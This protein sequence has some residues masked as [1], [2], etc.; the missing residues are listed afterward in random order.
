MQAI[1]PQLCVKIP[2]GEATKKAI[3]M[4]LPA[5]D[6]LNRITIKS[7]NPTSSCSPC[8]A[9]DR[10]PPSHITQPSTH[11]LLNRRDA[12]CV[13]KYSTKGLVEK[14]KKQSKTQTRSF[15]GFMIKRN[16]FFSRQESQRDT[17]KRAKYLQLRLSPTPSYFVVGKNASPKTRTKQEQRSKT[18]T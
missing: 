11:Y 16:S 12:P 4:H 1:T 17:Q 5:Q 15:S 8:K 7:Y 10:T 14:T 18:Y 9:M 13:I 6:A 2:R 3:R